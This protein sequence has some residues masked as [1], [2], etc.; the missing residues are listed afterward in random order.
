MQYTLDAGSGT[1]IYRLQCAAI[2]RDCMS[3]YAID[4]P[5]NI[6]L[7]ELDRQVPE[8]RRI[9]D[10]LRA[11]GWRMDH[12]RWVCGNHPP[13]GTTTGE[14]PEGGLRVVH[15]VR[16]EGPTSEVFAGPFASSEAEAW[17]E[18]NRTDAW[19]MCQVAP[20]GTA[21]GGAGA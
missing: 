8:D 20:P 19:T 16:M 1:V 21:Y 17:I 6:D 3:A 11:S 15:V 7:A 9:D 12:G 18:A 13:L 2:T 4:G 14:Q 5:R 10:L